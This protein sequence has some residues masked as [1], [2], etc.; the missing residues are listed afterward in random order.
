MSMMKQE[1]HQKFQRCGNAEGKNKEKKNHKQ[2]Y[3]RANE[4][5]MNFYTQS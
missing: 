1:Q 4:Q 5:N 3:Y 2:I